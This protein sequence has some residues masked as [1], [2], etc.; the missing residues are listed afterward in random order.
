MKPTIRDQLQS[1]FGGEWKAIRDGFGWRWSNGVKDV[2]ACS[3]LTPRYDGD[4]ETCV[5]AYED[6]CGVIVGAAGL[7]F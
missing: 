2:H 1:K 4:D 6:E 5:I 3:Q 7:I